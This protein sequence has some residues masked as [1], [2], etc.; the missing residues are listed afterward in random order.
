MWSD[1]NEIDD[2]KK[3]ANTIINE[4]MVVHATSLKSFSKRK[5]TKIER[6][7]DCD[8]KRCPTL[9]ERQKKVYPFPDSDVADMLE[10]LL[11]K[12]L[13][14]LL[15]CKRPEGNVDNPYCKYHRVMSYPVEKCFVLKELTIKLAY[16]NKIKLDIDEVAQMNQVVVN[17]ISSV[18]PSTQFYD[19]RKSLIQ[20]QTS[21]PI[22]VQFQQRIMTIDSQNKEE[23]VKDDGE[24]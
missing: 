14:Q 1:K 15:E 21:E 20:F 17:M 3:I 8:E 22:V 12:Q 9:K 7:H 5:E 11:E 23:H 16:E 4:S 13:I 2:T 24:G 10:Q 6:L 19:Q 18:P